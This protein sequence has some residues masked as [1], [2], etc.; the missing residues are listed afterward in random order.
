MNEQVQKHIEE[1]TDEVISLF[2]TVDG[3]N[4]G[5]ARFRGIWMLSENRK[6]DSA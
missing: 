2:K 5:Q 1:Y 6:S 4:C 3:Q